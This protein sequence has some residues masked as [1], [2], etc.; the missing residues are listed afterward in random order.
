M[1]KFL[2][3]ISILLLPVLVVAQVVVEKSS[4]KVKIDGKLFYVHIVKQGE[5]LYSISRAY[6]VSQADIATANPD[7]LMELKVGQALKIP[8]K[9]VP[10]GDDEN[11]IY[12]IVKRKETL[13]SLSKMYGISKEDII[14]FNPD[15]KDG[16]RVSQVVVLPQ[17]QAAKIPASSDSL[18]FVEYEVQK[19]EGLYAV[20]R[21]YGVNARDIELY[22]RAALV[23][24]VK[25]GTILR[26]PIP[27]QPRIVQDSVQVVQSSMATEQLAQYKCDSSYSYAGKPFNV[28][29]MLPFTQGSL[30]E[31]NAIASDL[32]SDVG[33][34]QKVSQTTQAALEFYEG[35]LLAADSMKAAGVSLNLSVFDTKRQPVE[36]S[37]ILSR[38]ELKKADL[39]IGSFFIDE[40]LP[41]SRFAVKHGINMVS[42]SYNGPTA[43]TSGSNVIVVNKTFNEQFD[44][45]MRDIQ[46]SNTTNYIIIYDTTDSYTSSYKFCDSVINT[47][48][49]KN[50]I[51][52]RRYNHTRG[53]NSLVAQ[54]LIYKLADTACT[55]VVIIPS[56]DEAFVSE[57]LGNIYGVKNLYGVK[58]AVYGPARW[59]R[60]KNI[61]TEYLY[62]LNLYI[63]TPFFVD[64]TRR[65]VQ[66]FVGN[67]RE[68]YRAEPSQLS[69][70]GYDV[71]LYFVSAL[72]KY[73]TN[74]IDCLPFYQKIGLQMDFTFRKDSKTGNTRNFDLIMVRYTSDNDIVRFK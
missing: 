31:S 45:F 7:I 72:K 19:G 9:S 73:G 38:D 30:N 64:Y 32:V 23:N 58:T 68:T 33:G 70:L 6:E 61:P 67:Y 56:E 69:F 63:Y 71:G 41:I 60:M 14:A 57:M 34:K 74:L 55:N 29:M 47:K 8:A 54:D 62:N 17:K 22:N 53:R 18:S 49:K 35:F 46:L 10:A 3:I 24:G 2:V 5:T 48:F 65:D 21:K 51:T 66:R 43:L 25:V 44:L 42:P 36:V 28:V 37:S 13:Y 15:V 11:Y 52:P 50:N 40:L 39:I 12:H 27:K 20:S 16:L 4:N 59:R 1:K 26:I